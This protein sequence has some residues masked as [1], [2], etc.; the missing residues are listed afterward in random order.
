MGGGLNLDPPMTL[1]CLW[2]I[3][4][5]DLVQDLEYQV[6]P[7]EVVAGQ[8]DAVVK[9]SVEYLYDLFRNRPRH[10]P[11]R[12][13]SWH[14]TT[15]YFTRALREIHRKFSAI[16]VDRLRV[17]PS[18]KITGEFYLQTVEGDPNYN[19]H[20][21][22]E[23]EGAQVYPA[24]IAVWMDYLLRLGLQTFEDYSGIERG[25]RLKLGA[26]RVVQAIYRW[27]YNRLRRAMGNLPHELPD[28]FEL[29]RLAAPYFHSRLDG[30]EG[31]MLV[32]KALWAYL[33]KKAHMI[34]ELS[35]YACMPNTMSVGAMA[36]VLGKY[37]DILYAPLE[38][39]GDAEVHALSRCQMI[40]TEARKRAQREF[41][42]A[43]VEHRADHGRGA[44]LPRRAPGDEAR[45]LSSAAGQRRRDR[46]ESGLA[47]RQAHRPE[48]TGPIA[49]PL[50][51][52]G[53]SGAQAGL[54]ATGSRLMPRMKFERS[55]SGSAVAAMSGSRRNSSTNIAVTSRRARCAA[56]AEVGAAGPECALLVRRARDVEAVGVREVFLVAI[57]GDVPHRD[58][59]IPLHLHAGERRVARDGPPHVHH[60]A[61]PP[62]DL[63]DRGRAQPVEVGL[64]LPLLVWEL[65]EGP[66]A[67]T[68]GRARGL[69]AGGDQQE[70]EGPEV[71]R[72]HRLA[73]DLG[74]HERGRQVVLRMFETL[75]AEPEP[76]VAQLAGRLQEGLARAPELLVAAGEEAVGQVEQPRPIGLRHAHHVADDSDGQRVGDLGDELR[77]ALRGDGVDDPP[78]ALPDR[79]FRLRDHLRSE[80]AVHDAPE[81]GVLRGIR[82]DHRA[83]GAH[84][85][86][87]LGI[88]HHL[89]PVR[90]AE[91]VPVARGG[92][93]V[94]E[95]GDRP[96][97]L[98]GVG[99]LMPGHRPLVPELGQRALHVVAQPEVEAGRVD[100]VQGQ[101]RRR[102][103][104]GAHAGL[105]VAVDVEATGLSHRLHSVKGTDSLAEGALLI[106]ST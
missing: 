45:H 39:K 75:P 1:G 37:P 70:E 74:V 87:V 68:D 19:I 57:G 83:D 92:R 12:S 24:A 42:D 85:L 104:N 30:G 88:G 40:L 60:R 47:R 66:H 7:Y 97:A 54:N 44:R 27:N 99:M 79:A 69:V 52:D 80:A 20:R 25:A 4:C 90:G 102:G 8:T 77:L 63:L 5:T 11:W 94:V 100:L 36:G 81:V 17:K 29:R 101:G 16:E 82:G 35:P 98:A 103:G 55:F 9:E 84:V 86:H 49:C 93:D 3:F 73:V 18:V 15:S 48:D 58:L 21:W 67:L 31:D 10:G 91:R 71:L 89:D 26:G 53:P 6:R 38:I 22:L 34:C 62:D 41:E 105:L 51:F 33:H 61:R 50:S 23:A 56:Q 106:R 72:R 43:L 14:L 65:R 76:V 46:G 32:G 64:P 2:A 59:L 96:E 28:Q 95:A 13:A 78:C